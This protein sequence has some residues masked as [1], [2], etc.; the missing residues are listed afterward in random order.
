MVNNENLVQGRFR[1]NCSV[2][3]TLALT[4]I[5]LRH[6]VKRSLVVDFELIYANDTSAASTKITEINIALLSGREIIKVLNKT[7]SATSLKLND[8]SVTNTSLSDDKYI[9]KMFE[10]LSR[11]CPSNQHC[12]VVDR[13]SSCV[14]NEADESTD[15][16]LVIVVCAIAAPIIILL[17][18]CLTIR[19][20][21][22]SNKL[23][24][25][26]G[27]DKSRPGYKW[28][29]HNFMGSYGNRLSGRY[30]KPDSYFP[31][32]DYY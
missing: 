15:L 17:V 1:L 18:I 2:T 12:S 16:M 25:Y 28:S 31:E 29:G 21:R 7:V 6:V 24:H 19:K 4:Q 10:A 30:F 11:M 32:H 14:F 26:N 3:L 22:N 13:Q 27:I 20:L 8:V 23:K 9:C 5:T